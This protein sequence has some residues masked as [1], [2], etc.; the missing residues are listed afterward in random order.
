M[1]DFESGTLFLPPAEGRIGQWSTYTDGTSGCIRSEVVV[2]ASSQALHVSGGGFTA[3]GAGFG[4]VWDWSDAQQGVCTYDLSAYSGIR[5][6]ARGNAW[7]RVTIPSR[8]TTPQ[9][10][11]GTC[12]NDA[13]CFDAHGRN[14]VLTADYQDFVLPFCTF[15]PQGWGPVSGPLDLSGATSLN[16]FIN[17]TSNFD[18]WIDDIALVPRS[19]D[20]GSAMCGPLCPVDQLAV[21]I[22]PAPTVTTLDQAGTGVHLYTFPQSTKDCGT[23]TRRYLAYV[24]PTLTASSSGSTSAPIVIVL[25]GSGVDAETMRT[26]TQARFETLAAQDGFIVV[27]GNAAPNSTTVPAFPN[28]GNFRR[29]ADAEID[30]VG[31]LRMIV[32]DLASRGTITGTNPV[33]LA[34]HSDGGGMAYIAG[35]RDPSRYL[36]LGL[37]M[38]FPGSPPPLPVPTVGSTIQRVLLSYTPG[39]QGCRQGSRPSLPP[40]DPPGPRR[41]GSWQMRS[42]RRSTPRSPIWSKKA[43]AIPVR[44]PMR[45]RPRTALRKRS[46]TAAIR[47]GRCAGLSASIIPDISGPCVTLTMTTR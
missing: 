6:R 36:G 20:A 9:S 29:D 13:S 10:A 46:T 43:T 4:T 11:G 44:W 5:F 18:V 34:G 26:V 47:P 25:H 30:D 7:L 45:S 39:I 31:Y 8:E 16:F 19:M 41:W 38:P 23:V 37:I 17:T 14:V 27:Y 2:D 3:M 12:P 22:V 40:W 1:D 32:A 21:G 33:F 24:P 42:R 15:A 35:L 28:G